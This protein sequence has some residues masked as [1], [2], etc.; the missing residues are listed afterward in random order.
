MSDDMYASSDATM[1][2]R[3]AVICK[4]VREVVER[5]NLQEL[6]NDRMELSNSE[7]EACGGKRGSSTLTGKLILR[8]FYTLEA[9]IMKL[10]QSSEGIKQSSVVSARKT[11]ES[12][13]RNGIEDLDNLT[14]CVKLVND[15]KRQRT[16]TTKVDSSTKNSPD[17]NRNKTERIDCD[18]DSAKEE[19]EEILEGANDTE[20]E[21]EDEE[22]EEE[23]EKEEEGRAE[24]EEEEDEEDEEDEDDED[25]EDDEEDED[26]E[27]DEE[28][29]EDEGG[30]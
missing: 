5:D 4:K 10:F 28:D 25:D 7:F 21:E 23:E 2:I 9:Q 20:D 22:D 16:D 11:L 6:F 12:I 18:S 13:G 8:H 15:F 14:R 1:L 29:E 27:D 26:D 3:T 19:E 30:D 17:Q 24:E